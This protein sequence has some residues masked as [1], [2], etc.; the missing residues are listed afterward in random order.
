MNTDVR[1]T[2][3]G[4][5][6]FRSTALREDTRLRKKCENAHREDDNQFLV[7]FYSPETV[8]KP[9]NHTR[10]RNRSP[11][12]THLRAITFPRVACSLLLLMPFGI[13]PLISPIS[14][15]Y[16]FS[17]SFIHD[18]NPRTL[19]YINVTCKPRRFHNPCFVRAS[20]YRLNKT[21]R[22]IPMDNPSNG[23]SQNFIALDGFGNFIE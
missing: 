7:Y 17:L 1:V 13:F 6:T 3:S 12:V 19:D 16:A 21:S 9:G 20:T 23:L 18:S 10:L 8:S 2:N 22:I 4:Y 11:L 14:A 5:F 15:R